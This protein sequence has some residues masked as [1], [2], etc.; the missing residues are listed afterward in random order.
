MNEKN[1]NDGMVDAIRLYGTICTSVGDCANCEVAKMS[2]QI[3]CAEYAKLQPNMFL[4]ALHKMEDN[5]HTFYNEYCS[6]MTK[7]NLPVEELADSICRKVAFEGYTSCQG[8]DC[9]A[10]WNEK[11]TNDITEQGDGSVSS[12]SNKQND[13]SIDDFVNLGL[14]NNNNNSLSQN[15]NVVLDNFNFMK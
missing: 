6:R 2:G 9:V 5:E 12:E 15:N 13:V 1:Y 3:S 14:L 10:C 11:Y 8:G 4:G 7:C